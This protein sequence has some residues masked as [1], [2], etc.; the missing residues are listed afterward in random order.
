MRENKDYYT[1]GP[2]K[3]KTLRML[4]WAWYVDFRGDFPIKRLTP[5]GAPPDRVENFTWQG[6]S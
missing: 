5:R 6:R 2:V 4:Q 3:M 1:S